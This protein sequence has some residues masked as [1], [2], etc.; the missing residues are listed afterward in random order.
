MLVTLGFDPG[1]KVPRHTAAAPV[2]AGSGFGVPENGPGDARERPYTS[3]AKP[4]AR[5]SEKTD[6]TT[7]AD[8]FDGISPARV[9]ACLSPT[10]CITGN[11]GEAAAA[12]VA[13]HRETAR[14]MLTRC[15]SGSGTVRV[16]VNRRRVRLSLLSK[17]NS[18]ILIVI[19][20]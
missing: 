14:S 10:G 6:A 4:V 16:E 7:N 13:T 2:G 15:A 17:Q 5:P 11:G 1:S 20:D 9:L 18:G 3:S 12:R 19:P 8:F